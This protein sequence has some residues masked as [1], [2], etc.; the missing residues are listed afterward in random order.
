MSIAQLTSL[1]RRDETQLGVREIPFEVDD[2]LTMILQFKN[3]CSMWKETSPSSSFKTVLKSL[4]SDFQRFQ[5]RFERLSS[6]EI[7]NALTV[8]AKEV[9]RTLGQI[10]PC[11]GCRTSVEKMYDEMKDYSHSALDP[12]VI[13]DENKLTIGSLHKFSP[14]MVYSLFYMHESKCN[15]MLEVISKSKKTKRCTIHSLETQKNKITWMANW[16][17]IWDD[18]GQEC[19][20]RI[21]KVDMDDLLQTIEKY[22]K[23]HRFCPECKDNVMIAYKLLTGDSTLSEEVTFCPKLYKEFRNCPGGEGGPC[24]HVLCETD[25]ITKLISRV[26]FEVGR[27]TKRERHAKTIGVAQEEIIT[28]IGLHLYERLIKTWQRLKAE[29]Q[30]WQILF[31]SG[32]EALKNSL[33]IALEEKEGISQIELVCQQ[34]EEADRAKQLKQDHKKD[35]K[36]LKK[37]KQK[38]AK[39]KQRETTQHEVQSVSENDSCHMTKAEGSI[40]DSDLPVML[41]T[42]CNIHG[43]VHQPSFNFLYHNTTQAKISFKDGVLFS[44]D[45]NE[46]RCCLS[47]SALIEEADRAIGLE[48]K[49]PQCSID[50]PHDCC[51]SEEDI[52]FFNCNKHQLLQQRQELR[53]KLRTRFFEMQLR[54]GCTNAG[55]ST[56][57]NSKLDCNEHESEQRNEERSKKKV[58]FSCDGDEQFTRA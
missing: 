36:R 43:Q 30:T 23:K 40:N 49:G 9:L 29:E 1:Y 27:D 44:I 48:A 47:L 57:F 3:P 16:K 20:Q 41:T 6:S 13:D 37:K 51:I 14:M 32:V 54:L 25:F 42:A 22:L 2:K 8:D 5:N 7:E 26:E 17:D 52:H 38:E 21:L 53:A 11:I 18:L 58:R 46:S 15:K 45:E 50:T 24:I 56:C 19:R 35:Q 33:E 55:H 12:F 34:L 31:F 28:C 10:F 4:K 39:N